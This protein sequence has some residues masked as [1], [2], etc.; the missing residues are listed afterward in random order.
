MSTTIEAYRRAMRLLDEMEESIRRA[1]DSSDK[2]SKSSLQAKREVSEWTERLRN[3]LLEH[4]LPLVHE[5][6][7][8]IASI[9]G[10]DKDMEED[11]VSSGIFGLMDALDE[12]EPDEHGP[13]EPWAS[14]LICKQIVDE[15]SATDWKIV[16]ARRPPDK[17]S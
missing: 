17:S 15:L 2:P 9:N 5:T 13:F 4:Y 3:Q 11:L 10:C 6:V 7:H 14:G 12:Y 1:A 16:F 8:R